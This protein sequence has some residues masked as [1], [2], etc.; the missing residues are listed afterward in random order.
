MTNITSLD[1]FNRMDLKDFPGM[2]V[3]IVNGK[4]AFKNKDPKIVMKRLLAQGKK[5]VALICVPET[6]MAMYV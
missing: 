2:A 1:R 3:G 4:I 5:E 6:K